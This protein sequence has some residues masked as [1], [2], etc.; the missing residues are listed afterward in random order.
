MSR[1]DQLEALLAE[2]P[3]DIFLRYAIAMEC[4]KEGNPE[5]AVERMRELTVA[6]PPHVPAFFM[7]AQYLTELGEIASA[8]T[9]LREGIEQARRQ[10]DQHAAGEM[11]EYLQTLGELGE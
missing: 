11:S 9:L 8:R 7:A 5:E 10:G 2:E 1:R 3:G 4:K 6:D